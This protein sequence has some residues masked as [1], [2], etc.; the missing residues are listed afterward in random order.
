MIPY[1]LFLFI[2]Y[3]VQVYFQYEN[4]TIGIKDL[5]EIVGRFLLGGQWLSGYV[6][7]FWFITCLYLTLVVY[8]LL[9]I[10]FSVRMLNILMVIF[11]ILAYID[12]IFLNIR[13]PWDFNVVLLTLPVFHCGYLYKKIK[14]TDLGYIIVFFISIAGV[15]V[16]HFSS[17]LSL[18]LKNVQYGIPFVSVLL[19]V[20]ISI[21]LMKI[22][23]LI[24][25]TLLSNI[26]K[27]VGVSSLVIMYVHQSLNVVFNVFFQIEYKLIV[28]LLTIS[29]SVLLYKILKKNEFTKCYFWG[30]TNNFEK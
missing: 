22:C 4:Q 12:S 19:S 11:L 5:F 24:E 6:T 8:N 18:D 16:E 23:N 17:N 29:V 14:I 1:V 7:V 25:K 2:I 3:P 30:Y 15:F 21:S 13:V 10:S 26:L 20:S 27:V 9:S 28:A